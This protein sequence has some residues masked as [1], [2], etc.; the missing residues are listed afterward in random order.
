MYAQIQ[1]SSLTE[2]AIRTTSHQSGQK[3]FGYQPAVGNQA[4]KWLP[5]T[6]AEITLFSLGTELLDEDFEG[7][8]VGYHIAL[9][10]RG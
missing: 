10:D 9:A 3:T 8:L 2:A 5:G 1:L 7:G 4:A 6:A